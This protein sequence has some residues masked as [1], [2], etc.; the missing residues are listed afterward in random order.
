MA[1]LKADLATV[2]TDLEVERNA[3][4]QGKGRLLHD[5][6]LDLLVEG[7]YQT[8]VRVIQQNTVN[9]ISME[10]Q[11]FDDILEDIAYLK[12][13]RKTEI[14]YRLPFDAVVSATKKYAKR[15][16]LNAEQIEDL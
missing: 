1:E 13:I 2:K 9:Q 10:Q 8:Y 15:N 4:V 3:R 6:L 7:Y 12:E 5:K 14:S 11:L 16:K